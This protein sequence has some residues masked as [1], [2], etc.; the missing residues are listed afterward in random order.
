MSIKD[1]A[2]SQFISTTEALFTLWFDALAKMVATGD[3][4][5]VSVTDRVAAMERF[6]TAWA[7]LAKYEPPHKSLCVFVEYTFKQAATK[8]DEDVAVSFIGNG[9]GMALVTTVKT[10][11][12][13]HAALYPRLGALYVADL[14]DRPNVHTYRS[15]VDK[16]A[17]AIYLNG[18]PIHTLQNLL[19]EWAHTVGTVPILV[20]PLH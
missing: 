5:A 4:N 7:N 1:R 18:T 20:A 12:P 15:E 14:L 17:T 11:S 3:R 10:R 13:Y 19:N 6:G 16:M 9:I 2:K 8:L